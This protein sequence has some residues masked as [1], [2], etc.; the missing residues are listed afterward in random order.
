MAE[1]E[2]APEVSSE[3][4]TAEPEKKVQLKLDE[5]RRLVVAILRKYNSENFLDFDEMLYR[6]F[7]RTFDADFRG[8]SPIPDRLE[9]KTELT[10]KGHRSELDDD[11]KQKFGRLIPYMSV[12]Y[13]NGFMEQLLGSMLDV[14]NFL[15]AYSKTGDKTRDKEINNPIIKETLTATENQFY[16]GAHSGNTEPDSSN[17]NNDP[18]K[19]VRVGNDNRVSNATDPSRIAV[20]VPITEKD[21]GLPYANA[22]IRQDSTE[23]KIPIVK[24]EIIETPAKNDQTTLLTSAMDHSSKLLTNNEKNDPTTL[25]TSAMDHSSKL[26]PQNT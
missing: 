5:T 24:A 26:L 15:T 9:K 4:P 21:Q 8:F 20:A 17:T 13:P 3:T 2:K 18:S 12:T 6:F 7:P 22:N 10:L 23:K 25:L 16:P 1:K 19:E 14:E 11:D